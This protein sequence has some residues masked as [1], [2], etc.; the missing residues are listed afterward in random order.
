MQLSNA[1]SDFILCITSLFVFFRFVKYLP[2]NNR[3]L[4]ATFLVLI[5][6]A[7]AVGTLRFSGLVA[8]IPI[9][10]S[11]TLLGGTVGI[12]ALTA[13]IGTLSLQVIAPRWALITVWATGL[14][15]FFVLIDP[16]WQPFKQVVTALG[17]LMGM[18]LAV[19]GLAQKNQKM[20]W[21][22]V[23]IMVVGL[24][25]KSSSF[26][27]SLN[28]TDVYHYGLAIAIICFGKSIEKQ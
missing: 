13:A 19:W 6:L 14:L 8:V 17:I 20:I 23:G 12:L 25:T 3:L 11:L 7:A 26:W 15:L 22:I 28:A 16:L 5:A 2:L 4:W 18:L 24:S 9:H 21:V 10:Q 1:I 27:P